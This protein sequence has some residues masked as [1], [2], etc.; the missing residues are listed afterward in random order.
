MFTIGAVPHAGLMTDGG[1]PLDIYRRFQSLLWSG[2]YSRLGEEDIVENGD[3]LVI[4]ARMEATHS[5]ELLGVPATGRL[6]SY[7]AVDMFRVQDGRI[8]WRFLPCDWHGV[9]AQLTDP[10][11]G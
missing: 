11:R 8:V 9:L 10:D 1:S 7:D 2:D 5:G 3:T 4:R 6:I